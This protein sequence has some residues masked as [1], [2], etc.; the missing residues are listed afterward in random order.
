MLYNHFAVDR[1]QTYEDRGAS[2]SC[3]DQINRLPFLKTR[4]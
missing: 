1:I 3:Y 2:L 4:A